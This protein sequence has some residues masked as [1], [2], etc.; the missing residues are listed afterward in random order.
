MEVVG[1]SLSFSLVRQLPKLCNFW[2]NLIR[3]L[4]SAAEGIDCYITIHTR[5]YGI[6]SPTYSIIPMEANEVDKIRF[7]FKMALICYQ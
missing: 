1:I 2:S 7:E 5:Y 4:V 6:V 3:D